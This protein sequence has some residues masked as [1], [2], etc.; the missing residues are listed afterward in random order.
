M[1]Q[2]HFKDEIYYLKDENYSKS[3][4]MV[5]LM[6]VSP[7]LFTMI[8][9][10]KNKYKELSESTRD[11]IFEINR[12]L[13]YYSYVLILCLLVR[14]MYLDDKISVNGFLYDKEVELDCT[15]KSFDCCKIYDKCYNDNNQINSDTYVYNVKKGGACHTL[16]EM[17]PLNYIEEDC[18][19]SEFG[20][21]YIN[22]SCDSY[23]RSNYSFEIYERSIQKGFPHGYVNTGKTKNDKEGS[24]CDN[25][26]DMILNHV[27]NNNEN[28]FPS[29]TLIVIIFILIN[30]ILLYRDMIYS[31][32]IIIK[33]IMEEKYKNA[34]H[35]EKEG[36]YDD[37][38]LEPEE[39][40]CD[41]DSELDFP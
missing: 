11:C 20:C 26:E 40:I 29:L 34:K 1:I 25:L 22:T 18:E 16:N 3:I 33:N 12:V 19:D 4:L 24:N 23:K 30:M 9:S 32:I 15:D 2:F 35:K 27:N 38:T 28:I 37:L 36:N 41:S 10:K 21:C 5:I 17:I 13:L 7:I 31:K 8:V 39:K 14:F 6:M